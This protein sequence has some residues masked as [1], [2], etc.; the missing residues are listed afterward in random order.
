M[1]R[2]RTRTE[3]EVLSTDPELG[4]RVGAD[5][6]SSQASGVGTAMMAT[7]GVMLFLGLFAA[8]D[9]ASGRD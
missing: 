9:A 6:D 8:G 7:L 5:G 2:S 1:R 3:D 4:A